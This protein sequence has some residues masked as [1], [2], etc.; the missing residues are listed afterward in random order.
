MALVPK[1]IPN[2]SS[3]CVAMFLSVLVFNFQIG[4]M[5]EKV[6]EVLRRPINDFDDTE[7]DR[8][9]Y[10]TMSTSQHQNIREE[11]W[12]Q[13]NSDE[14]ENQ[15]IQ[16][17]SMFRDEDENLSITAGKC[18]NKILYSDQYPNELSIL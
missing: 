11:L 4:H 2:D 5:F 14:D 8:E 16:R 12:Q 15:S 7:D 3:K 18:I 17:S 13:K 9:W 10:A 1:M 6:N